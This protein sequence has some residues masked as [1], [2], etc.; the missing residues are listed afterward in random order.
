MDTVPI[1]LHVNGQARTLEVS[2]STMLLDVLRE[3]LHLTG[4]KNGCGQG[5][6][7]A[8]T[9][10]VNGE[11]V[12]SCITKA[13]RLDGAQVETIEGLAKG[14]SLHPVQAA[15]I[16]SGAI[17]CGFC[18]P[19]MVMSV[20]ALLDASPDPT[21]AEIDLALEHNLCRCTGYGSIIRAI[22]RA[23]AA[24]PADGWAPCPMPGDAHTVGRSCIRPDAQ[25]KV[26]G[27]AIYAA[28]LRFPGMLHAKVLRSQHAHARVLRVNAS[29]AR[30]LPGVAAVLTADE[31]PGARKNG[32]VRRDWPIL[33]GVGETVRYM[34]D[35]LALVAAESE[36]IARQALAL[37]VVDYQPLP[38]VFSA[39][40]ALAPGAPLLH[41]DAPGNLLKHIPVRKGDMATGWSRATEIVEGEFTTPFIEHA[42]L[43]PEAGV[44][45]PDSDGVTVYVGSQI[46]FDDR[47]VVAET[48]DLPLDKV[49]IIATAVGGAFGGKEDV[50]VQPLVALL[51]KH[52]G[53]PVK[54]VFTR[55]ESILVHPK[56]HPTTIRI[57]LGASADGRL[58]AV[59]ATIWGDSGAYASLGEH[60]MT[61]TATHL[62]GPYV[63]PNVKVDCYAAYTNNPPA[64]AMRGF[65]VPQAAFA[66]ES[67]M[68]MLARRLGLHP[69]ELRR[70]NALRVGSVTS[71]GQLLTESVGLVETIDKVQAEVERLGDGVLTPSAPDRLRAWGFAC[72]IKNVGVGGGVRDAAGA[73]VVAN[74]NG[75]VEVRIGAAEVGQGLVT[76]AVQIAAEELSV[77]YEAV[78]V[79]VGDT[80][81]TPDGGATTASRQTF[82][83]GN[84]VRRAARQVRRLLDAGAGAG[85]GP[86]S[87]SAEYVAPAT[88]RLGQDGD[89]HFAYGFATQAAL[90]EVNKVSGQ[91]NVLK[92]I[93]AHDVGRALNPEAVRG[94]VEG[95]VVMGV[96]FALTE[97]LELDHGVTRNP[98]LRRYRVPHIDAAPDVTCILVE[99]PASEGPFGAK[100]VGEITSIPT[101]P[102][103]T[104]AIFA[105]TG[106]RVTDL[107]AILPAPLPDRP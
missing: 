38:G 34:G 83:T 56:R 36:A 23:S 60:V 104:N 92:V 15:F 70:R 43:E 51:A 22:R 54:L 80:G 18:T 78:S 9:V 74:P 37:I 72:C 67:A 98:D 7:G 2:L 11:A 85:D 46:P 44:A 8:C 71:C 66:M 57:K 86:V 31:I 65:G 69:L 102:A 105:A 6:C 58:T 76:V 21:R 75:Q 19:G 107:P 97:R 48:L 106:L 45:V 63:A 87:A 93:A 100:G 29:R 17:Q 84:A 5:H 82:V 32:H 42:F 16:A 39:Q 55:Q 14:G 49:R 3:D 1:T 62:A 59:E 26:T 52:T 95:G 61:R 25:E 94:Q 77:P 10:I 12:R 89:Q 41:D 73:E 81:K 53:H 40:E 68:D 30:S 27:S 103:I 91:V 96:G 47:R 64:G 4:T 90:V 24:P 13:A 20:K 50:S 33:V 101:A 28:D 79:L 99:A 35:A 88:V